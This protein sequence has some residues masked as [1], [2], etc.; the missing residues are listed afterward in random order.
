MSSSGALPSRAAPHRRHADNANAVI[1]PRPARGA[2]NVP[3][4]LSATVIT[5]TRTEDTANAGY[6]IPLPNIPPDSPLRSAFASKMPVA[7]ALSFSRQ[8]PSRCWPASRSV[9]VCR[10]QQRVSKLFG[11]HYLHPSECRRSLTMFAAPAFHI[12]RALHGFRR[13]KD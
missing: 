2:Y 13:Q 4:A 6:R 7:I 11:R 1:C 9:V 12:S 10:R 8:S 3:T 5:H